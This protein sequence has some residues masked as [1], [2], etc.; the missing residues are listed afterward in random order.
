MSLNERDLP[1]ATGE[2]TYASVPNAWSIPT[3]QTSIIVKGKP[4]LALSMG[5]HPNAS[6]SHAPKEEEQ[7]CEN[8]KYAATHVLGVITAD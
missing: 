2:P 4:V 7:G 8:F 6:P 1:D 3:T 5:T